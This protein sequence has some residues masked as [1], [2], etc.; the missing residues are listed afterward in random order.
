MTFLQKHAAL[1]QVV[2]GL[3]YVEPDAEDLHAH[4]N[5]V[6]VPLNQLDEKALCPG[7]RALDKINASL[8]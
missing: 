5:T 6:E 7:S 3:L 4:L 2:T 1:G 8:R